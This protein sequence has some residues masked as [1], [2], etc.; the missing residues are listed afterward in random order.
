M[1][2]LAAESTF[3]KIRAYYLEDDVKLSAK[4][5]EIRR[6]WSAAF[7]AMVND[8]ES[9]KTIV[10]ML[11]KQF[12]ICENLGYRDLT[13]AK[14][15]F[16]DVRKSDKEALRYMVT[17]W[18]KEL[19]RLAREKKDFKGMEKALER[20]TKANNLDKEDQDLPDPSK[21]QPPVQLL[22]ITYNFINSPFFEQC[23]QKV[24]DGLLALDAQIKALLERSP[25]KDYLDLFQISDTEY[26]QEL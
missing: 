14:H 19:F 22:S 9:D 12:G 18:S 26:E 11:V 5:E 20:I 4:E 13:N 23:D 2:I 10:A 6:R 3:D 16:G 8:H 21:I 24:K 15:L 17:E 7:A 1:K 25:M